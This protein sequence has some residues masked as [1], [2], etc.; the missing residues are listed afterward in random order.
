LH[1]P[2][3][4]IVAIAIAVCALVAAAAVAAERHR[5]LD[6]SKY[7]AAVLYEECGQRRPTA[8]GL[9]MVF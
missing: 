7:T 9:S 2:Q 3:L 6:I 8:M 1:R 5:D 4:G